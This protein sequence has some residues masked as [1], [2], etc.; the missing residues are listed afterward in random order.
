MNKQ[1]Q[2]IITVF[3]FLFLVVAQFK[4]CK[5]NSELSI[6]KKENIQMQSKMDSFQTKLPIIIQIEGFKISKRMLYDNNSVVRTKERPD[7]IMVTYD[8]KIEELEKKLVELSNEN[9]MLRQASM[10]VQ[11]E[12]TIL[13]TE[14][15]YIKGIL[16]TTGIGGLIS[17][18]NALVAEQLHHKQL[19]HLQAQAQTPGTPT[20]QT[21]P[22][23]VRLP[24]Q[25]L[26]KPV[27]PLK[28]SGGVVLMVLLLSFGLMFGNVGFPAVG[29][30]P[31][32]EVPEVLAGRV[33]QKKE[34]QPVSNSQPFANLME[35]E[36]APSHLKERLTNVVLKDSVP[37]EVTA[38]ELR[39]KQDRS[40]DILASFDPTFWKA[41]TTYLMCKDIQQLTVPIQVQRGQDDTPDLS[42]LIPP[43]TFGEETGSGEEEM[44][45]AVTCRVTDVTMVPLIKQS[46]MH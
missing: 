45:L 28:S 32:E 41:N 38:Q 39:T 20:P 19:H 31:S 11:N 4:S 17:R 5:T 37:I 23:I 40:E 34:Y 2:I 21:Q 43:S 15:E 27:S 24:P 16:T 29:I 9:A 18:G 35:E 12:N 22:P 6:L 44:L 26:H 36:I 3:V 14:N 13:R 8:T 30:R 42:F 1:T 33:F 7:D 46:A 25:T 10:I